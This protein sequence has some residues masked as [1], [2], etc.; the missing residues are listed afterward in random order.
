MN[1]KI[2]IIIMVFCVCFIALGLLQRSTLFRMRIR[3]AGPEISAETPPMIVFTT[4]V[5]GGFRGIIADVLWLRASILQEE[6]RFFEL[7][8]LA[9]WITKLEPR[10][11]EVWSFHAWNM[12]YN[13][14][15][16]MPEPDERWRWIRN[17]IKLLRDEGIKYNP[18]QPALFFELAWIFQHKIGADSD[19][20]HP[21]YKKYWATEMQNIFPS[22]FIPD[23]IVSQETMSILSKQYNMDIARMRKVD[24]LYGPLDWRLP[25]SHA[26]Y[27]AYLGR[28]S[29]KKE[30]H[31]PCERVIYQC[32]VRMTLRG[33]LVFDTG[34]EKYETSP[35]FRL[36]PK[37]MAAYEALLEK[38]AVDTILA[39]Y[40]YFMTDLV[41]EYKN[42]NMRREAEDTLEYM[43]KIFPPEDIMSSVDEFVKFHEDYAKKKHT[44]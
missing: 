42:K 13:V 34:S 21:Y 24:A 10:F 27:W 26:V 8:Q 2:K 4:V 18:N 16:M 35:D 41:I 36:A 23:E 33:K 25:C 28:Q 1:K 30:I 20:M 29:N 7:V 19:L 31:L 9:D 44:D 11:P 32:M 15:V 22:G 6:G 14:S 39:S 37:T 43:K 17:G 3:E 38:N 40:Y 12:A 5:L